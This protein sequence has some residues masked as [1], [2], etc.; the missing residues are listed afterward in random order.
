MNILQI[1]NFILMMFNI[2]LAFYILGWK[3][4]RDRLKDSRIKELKQENVILRKELSKTYISEKD[5]QYLVLIEKMKKFCP[6]DDLIILNPNNYKGYNFETG[7]FIKF[8]Q[9][10]E[11]DE[12]ETT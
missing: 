1:I 2:S 3:S 12:N 5:K 6:D 10:E 7:K 8:V 9:V 4:Y 11:G